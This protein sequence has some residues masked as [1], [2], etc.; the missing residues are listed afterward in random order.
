[1]PLNTYYHKLLKKRGCAYVIVMVEVKILKKILILSLIII[2]GALFSFRVN[3]ST[4]SCNIMAGVVDADGSN[5][6]VRKSTS[7]SS[8]IISKVSDKSYLTILSTNGN[9]YYVEYSENQY[10]YV[11]ADYVNIV[12]KNATTVNTQG[13]NL[14]VRYSPS[15]TS[16]IVEKIQDRDSVVILS[17]SNNWSKVLF[18]GNKTG[19]VSSDYLM[20]N[21]TYPSISLNVVSYKQY[22]SRWANAMIGSSGQTFKQIGCLTTAMAMSESYR[23][24]TTITPLYM[25]SLLN[26]TSTGLMYWPSNYTFIYYS[27]D[28]LK[29]VYNLLKQGKP[30]IMGAKTQSGGQHWVLIYGYKASDVLSTSNFLIHDPGS[31]SRTTL[32]QFLAAYP[33][34]Y[35]ISY[36]NN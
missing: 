35:K 26:Y 31:S 5:L 1:M 11:Y 36:Y 23:R 32:N 29:S 8:T 12:S 15:I 27:N 14:N 17:Q 18:E 33:V 7:T 3:A 20:K 28:Y 25:E 30:V 19:Y 22:D 4:S 34:F 24:K 21:Y 2:T 9:W 16:Q 13:Y 10:G 6:H